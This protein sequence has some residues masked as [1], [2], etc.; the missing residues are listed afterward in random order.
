M[1]GD[2]WNLNHRPVTGE[3]RQPDEAAGEPLDGPGRDTETPEA[4]AEAPGGAERLAELVGAMRQP[5]DAMLEMARVMNESLRELS[6]V[7]KGSVATL[8]A[9]GWPEAESRQLVMA[10]TIN[11]V[12]PSKKDADADEEP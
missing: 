7:M 8:V 5:S 4:V 9:E 12:G 11:A 2:G 10:M 6:D 3:G 1:I